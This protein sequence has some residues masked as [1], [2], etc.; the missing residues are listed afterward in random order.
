M[1]KVY[2][3]ANA[4]TSVPRLTVNLLQGLFDALKEDALAFLAGIWTAPKSSGDSNI[5]ALRHASA[6]LQAHIAEEDGIDFQT[7]L[8][9]L[10]VAVQSS[11][12]TQREA[13]LTCIAQLR[14]LAEGKFSAVYKFDVVYGQSQSMEI[15]LSVALWPNIFWLLRSTSISGSR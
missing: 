6:F 13:A 15:S 3:L 7:I 12:Q 4:S 5:V 9:S 8:P 2:T 11:D 10:I 1:R 14:Q